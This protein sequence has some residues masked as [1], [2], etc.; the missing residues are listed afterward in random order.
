MSDDPPPYDASGSRLS[1]RL[2]DK[3]TASHS[4]PTSSISIHSKSPAFLRPKSNNRGSGS[5]ST[6]SGHST[7]KSGLLGAFRK[8][9][10]PDIQT[11]RTAVTEDVRLAVHPNTGSI[12]ERVALLESCAE[13]C[14][15]HKI[16]F[17]LLLQQRDK[18]LFHGHTALYWAIVNDL[19][20][21][22]ELVAAVLAHSAPLEPATIT[23]AR[24]AC[25]SLSN[26]EIFQFLRLCPEFGVLDAEDRFLLGV[27]VPPDEIDLE[28]M[29]GPAEPFS[30]T[31]KVPH[32]RK[33]MQLSRQIK[34]EFIARGRLWRLSFFTAIYPVEEN[35]KDGEWSGRLQLGEN[36]PST[37]VEFGVVFL[38]PRKT[39][40]WVEG[41]TGIKLRN[42]YEPF[43]ELMPT[44]FS[45]TWPLFDEDI[46]QADNIPIASD[47]SLS[48][49]LGMKLPVN[50]PTPRPS[51]STTIPYQPEDDCVVC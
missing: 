45:W 49:I 34:L 3:K 41:R 1:L 9:L 27:L 44:S 16:N 29:K 6:S 19:G 48:G 17:S 42:E 21:P 23:E 28:L 18:I 50:A 24:R 4:Q 7:A 8:L 26:Q 35:L 14:A 15:R 12:A 47:G 11:V 22:F 5:K 51:P 46:W 43:N 36:S 20:P 13:L 39:R 32:F 40:R 10:P 37:H 30:V 33:R 2:D 31:F 38:D 25:I